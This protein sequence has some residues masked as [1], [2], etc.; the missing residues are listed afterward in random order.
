[1]GRSPILIIHRDVTHKETLWWSVALS[2]SR[3][4]LQEDLTA[5]CVLLHPTLPYGAV[6]DGKPGIAVL[7]KDCFHLQSVQRC[8]V[9]VTREL[10]ILLPRHSPLPATQALRSIA[11]TLSTI[12][13]EADRTVFFLSLMVWEQQYGELLKHRTIPPPESGTH[14]RW[15]YTHGNIRRAWRLL[16]L[17]PATLFAFLDTPGIPATNNSLEGVNRHLQRRVGMGKGKQLS[18]MLW[19]LALSRVQTAVQKK[20]LWDLWKRR[21]YHS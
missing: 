2:E 6:T 21:L 10:K 8:V 17:D 9:H 1:M 16:N 5:L 14:R 3:A 20:Q 7:M 11:V 4:A 19:K 15:W 13:T 12:A 18:L